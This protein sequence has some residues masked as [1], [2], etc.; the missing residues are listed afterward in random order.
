LRSTGRPSISLGEDGE[1]FQPGSFLLEQ[2][3]YFASF[4]LGD[5]FF[6]EQTFNFGG[7]KNNEIQHQGAKNKMKRIPVADFKF[8]VSPQRI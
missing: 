4:N 2:K 5:F 6:N 3:D 7:E 1:N 8:R